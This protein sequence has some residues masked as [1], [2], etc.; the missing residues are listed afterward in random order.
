V[1]ERRCWSRPPDAV[2]VRRWEK[3]PPAARPAIPP[4]VHATQPSSS[5]ASPTRH[6]QHGA[7][8]TRVIQPMRHRGRARRSRSR[9]RP[10]S[11]RHHQV[12][13]FNIPPRRPVRGTAR[14]PRPREVIDP[15]APYW[16]RTAERAPLSPPPTHAFAET[17][18][19]TGRTRP[20]SAQVPPVLVA[21]MDD[22]PA[23]R[24]R[25]VAYPS[26]S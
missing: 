2:G 23:R 9:C 6:Q 4:I 14:A 13:G 5:C 24:R 11:E 22:L 10:T 15:Y 19:T 20:R 16:R 21:Q 3:L 18:L 25:G 7:P 26:R 1:S 17:R 12:A 8:S